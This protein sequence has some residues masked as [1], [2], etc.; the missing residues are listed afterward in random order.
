MILAAVML[1]VALIVGTMAFTTSVD[2][3][4]AAAGG[5][6]AP[7]KYSQMRVASATLELV[8]TV[9][10]AILIPLAKVVAP[11]LPSRELGLLD[12][13]AW[14]LFVPA[15]CTVHFIRLS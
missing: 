4:L 13:S 9:I 7:L 12:L 15:L 3:R 14:C 8:A 2:F 10:A 11:E 5:G 6:Q 1:L